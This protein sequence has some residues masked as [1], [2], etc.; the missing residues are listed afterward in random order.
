VTG[1]AASVNP[2][3]PSS[4]GY[5]QRMAAA[6]MFQR[7]SMRGN[8]EGRALSPGQL[9]MRTNAI[10]TTGADPG[11]SAGGVGMGGV[12]LGSVPLGGVGGGGSWIPA[13]TTQKITPGG[14]DQNAFSPQA[15]TVENVTTPA[16]WVLAS[17]MS[18]NPSSNPNTSRKFTRS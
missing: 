4:P 15:A 7:Q 8:R 2:L 5:A 18:N 14:G 1:T 12:P 11:L 10:A 17:L 16:R 9:Q 13:Q 3:N 6:E